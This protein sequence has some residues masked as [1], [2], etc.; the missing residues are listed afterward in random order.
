MGS[1]SKFKA[2][3]IEYLESCHVGQFCTGSLDEV[4]EK[5]NQ[6]VQ[7][8]GY[9]N[10]VESLP[11]RVPEQ[12]ADE[13]GQCDQCKENKAWWDALPDILVDIIF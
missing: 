2:E 13:C 8:D 6:D 11:K 7:S 3:M 1:D 4:R 12:C 5:V 10:P 9:I